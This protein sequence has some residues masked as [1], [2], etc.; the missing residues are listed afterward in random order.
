MRG[1]WCGRM[2]TFIEIFVQT[3]N[4]K[5]SEYARRWGGGGI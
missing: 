1:E 3:N 4:D 2:D 5:Y